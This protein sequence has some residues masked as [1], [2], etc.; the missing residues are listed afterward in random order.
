[1]GLSCHVWYS[2]MYAR[3][4]GVGSMT[5]AAKLLEAHTWSA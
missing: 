2:Y 3:D 5:A 1:M 4:P